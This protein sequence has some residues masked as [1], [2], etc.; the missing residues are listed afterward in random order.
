MLYCIKNISLRCIIVFSVLLLAAN[1][2]KNVKNHVFENYYRI[3]WAAANNLILEDG[4]VHVHT[5][6]HGKK[7]YQTL[8]CL[9]SLSSTNC[10]VNAITNTSQKWTALYKGCENG[11]TSFVKYLILNWWNDIDINKK[12]R[13]DGRTALTI[14]IENKNNT[15][16]EALF[17]HP[18]TSCYK[19]YGKAFSP[20][21]T[22][23]KFDNEE[24]FNTL[25][26]KKVNPNYYCKDFKFPPLIMCV[27]ENNLKYL[28][29]LLRLKDIEVNKPIKGTKNTAL[30]VACE[31]DEKSNRS[32]IIKCLINH[33]EID[34][35]DESIDAY[36]M[37]KGYLSEYSS[38]TLDEEE[39]FYKL[40]EGLI[41]E[42]CLDLV[43]GLAWLW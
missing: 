14:S 39:Y 36:L 12:G 6:E 15:C 16:M 29:K 41:K 24:A 30:H 18:S 27:H 37:K 11:Y 7:H 19:Y 28:K 2:S 42:A 40:A 9:K 5:D 3:H 38:I 43:I 31:L 10:D 25:I 1:C 8:P 23:C 35:S 32:S 22:A 33:D 13:C 4:K 34:I 21:Y 20:L 26:Q 17:A